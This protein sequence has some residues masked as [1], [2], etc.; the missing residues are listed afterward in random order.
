MS[1]V[2]FRNRVVFGFS[3]LMS[4]LFFLTVIMSGGAFIPSLLSAVLM[5]IMMSGVA[6]M[7]YFYKGYLHQRAFTDKKQASQSTDHHQTRTV[8]ID[9]PQDVAFDLALDALQTLDKQRVPVP[10]DILVKLENL[11]PRKQY[12]TIHDINREQGTI[13]AGLK[14][15]VMGRPEFFDFSRIAIRIEKVNTTTTRVYT[16]S[17]AR[18]VLDT[19]DF[20][21]NLHYVNTIA[22]YLR[23]ESQQVSA[24]LRLRE[25]NMTP[26]IIYDDNRQDEDSAQR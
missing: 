11:L 12:L 5:G 20:G 23:R 24:E 8:E 18:S 10:D 1:Q 19:Y 22:L 2:Q 21:K 3:L 17:K 4:V 7:S 25:D 16:E 13:S 6:M 9:L 26:D 15:R 14:A